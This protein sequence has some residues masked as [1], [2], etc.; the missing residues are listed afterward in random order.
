[1]NV[2]EACS[3]EKHFGGLHVTRNVSL[4]IGEGERIGLIGP[5]GAGK[6]TLVNMLAGSLLPSEGSILLRGSDVT[7]LRQSGRVKRGLCRTFQITQLAMDLPIQRQVE[8]A[9]HAR[10]KSISN[11]IRSISSYPEIRAEAASHLEHLGIGHLQQRPPSA[12]A[13]GEQRL[14][15]LAIAMALRPKVL[16][17]DEPMAGVPSTYRDKVLG[18]LARLP[19]ELAILMI[20]HDMDLVF[21]FAQRIVVL[22]HGSVIAD[23]TPGTIRQ[24]RGVREAYLG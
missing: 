21:A 24:D 8:L 18:T 15:E 9:I 4:G 13:Y 7:R 19:K 2:L 20:E 5:N 6:T 16:L 23:G 12:I 17:L 3:L 14:V 10:E 1:M 11:M 22:A